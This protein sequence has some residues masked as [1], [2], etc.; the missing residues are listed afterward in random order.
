MNMRLPLISKRSKLLRCAY[1]LGASAFCQQL[2]ETMTKLSVRLESVDVPKDSFAA[3]PK[4]IYRAG[5][6]YCRTEELPDLERGIHGLMIL[7]EP[8]AWMVNLITKTAQHFVDSGPTFSCHLPIFRGPQVKSAAD[9]KD[10][11]LELEFGQ[12]LSYFKGKGAAQKEGPIL[13]HK[14]TTVYAVDIGDSQLFLFTTE[15]PERPWAVARKHNNVD[16]IFWYG[17]YEQ[18]PFDQKLFVRPEGVKIVEVN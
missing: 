18:Q 16:Q 12:E 7:N 2:P 10:S 14:P 13:R 3:K 4:V 9:M 5:N 6:R 8:D 17:T 1:F 11:L 15:T